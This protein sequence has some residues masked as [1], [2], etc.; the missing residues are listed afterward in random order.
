MLRRACGASTS[1]RVLETDTVLIVFWALLVALVLA[2]FAVGHRLCSHVVRP[3][4]F[5]YEEGAA[6]ERA[7]FGWVEGEFEA[8]EK[9]L[10]TIASRDGT[11]LACLW[12]A[13]KEK[14]PKA[15][16]LA[17]GHGCCAINSYK[18]AKLFLKRGYNALL[19]DFR[20]SGKSGGRVTTLGLKEKF[21]LKAAVDEAFFRLGENAAV[22]THG[23]S[24]G[25]A[26]VI[27][28]ACMDERLSFAVADCSFADMYEQIAYSLKRG[29]KLPRFPFLAFGALSYRL[30]AGGRM[31]DVSPI[32]ALREQG[33]LKRLPMLFIHGAEDSYIRPAAS[34][35]LYAAKAGQK[36]LWL[37]E[38]AKHARSIAEDPA[39]YEAQL[40]AF[41]EENGL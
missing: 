14:S 23:E 1:G 39:G 33:G 36:R 26:T 25:A 20:N 6:H 10:F 40:S 18:Y 9:E 31:K 19:I 27:L 29:F 8:L 15:V 24:M 30:R 11:R 5:T 32:R 3:R 21:D 28:E 17:H 34:E 22:G 13:A 4:H 37:C 41:L 7:Y 35:A 2:G 16:V 12:I 38:G